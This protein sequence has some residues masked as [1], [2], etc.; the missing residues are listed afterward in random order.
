MSPKKL[1]KQLAARRR[2]GRA[3]GRWLVKLLIVLV[4]AVLL[5]GGGA[6]L[7][8]RMLLNQVAEALRLDRAAEI[9]AGLVLALPLV[10]VAY[11]RDIV[12]QLKDES[13]PLK[14]SLKSFYGTV[15]K[16]EEGARVWNVDLAD[17]KF[18]RGAGALAVTRISTGGSY[19]R[20]GGRIELTGGR[21]EYLV[22][23]PGRSAMT[24]FT[25]LSFKRLAFDVRAG[26]MALGRAEAGFNP[27]DLYWQ[28]DE[29]R[30]V[31]LEV[32][33]ASLDGYAT[34]PLNVSLTGYN[35][36]EQ[37]AL[38]LDM[39]IM[40]TADDDLG[41][42]QR[43]SLTGLL[44]KA[45]GQSLETAKLLRFDRLRLGGGGGWAGADTPADTWVESAFLFPRLFTVTINGLGPP[46]SR[47]QAADWLGGCFKGLD[48]DDQPRCLAALG[49]DSFSVDYGDRGLTYIIRPIK[50]FRDKIFSET[51]PSGPLGPPALGLAL[52]LWLDERPD[53]VPAG[54][55]TFKG[56]NEAE[57][58][59]PFRRE[60][61][62]AIQDGTVEVMFS[63]P[64]K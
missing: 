5:T 43:R 52:G 46:V 41:D 15:K 6:W 36:A 21:V 51:D 55:F 1:E 59:H 38:M 14:F 48:D 50:S 44:N 10:N 26:L 40:R 19:D 8:G 28:I 47:E 35:N 27:L 58:L 63:K 30:L 61:L 2:K 56:E 17:I 31:K 29:A 42:G 25:R 39:N 12:V 9:E 7:A 54:T 4:L 64:A 24:A 34:P 49:F 16:N 13:P 60:F 20:A 22:L 11:G 23:S 57:R 33:L 53:E 3:A 32:R 62:T 18:E 45:V 37:W